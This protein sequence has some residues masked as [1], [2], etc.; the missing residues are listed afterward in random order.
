MSDLEVLV[1]AAVLFVLTQLP[2]GP[3]VGIGSRLGLVFVHG[4]QATCVVSVLDVLDFKSKRTE[5]GALFRV[6]RVV[7][8]EG[9]RDVMAV[10][11]EALGRDGLGGVNGRSITLRFLFGVLIVALNLDDAL[12]DSLAV[13]LNLSLL[14]SLG[15]GSSFI[16]CLFLLK[17]GLFFEAVVDILA[18][19]IHRV[20]LAIIESLGEREIPDL[21]DRRGHL[22]LHLRERGGANLLSNIGDLF[23]VV[24][25]RGIEP[26]DV[27]SLGGGKC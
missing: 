7:V 11:F 4:A 20:A 23:I 15:L 18:K 27:D 13:L 1:V 5:D 19:L 22:L 26:S 14:V 17:L 24:V 3:G 8:D 10:H 16:A 6:D 25:E 21:V 2:V 12:S 9:A